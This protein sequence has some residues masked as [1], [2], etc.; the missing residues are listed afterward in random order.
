[1]TCGRISLVVCLALFSLHGQ[2]AS[3]SCSGTPSIEEA[4]DR[5]EVVFRGDVRELRIVKHWRQWSPG[6]ILE[7]IVVSTDDVFISIGGGL[8]HPEQGLVS[9]PALYALFDVD[10][11]WKGDGSRSV[12]IQTSASE[13]SCGSGFNIGAQYLVYANWSESAQAYLTGLCTR[14]KRLG[15]REA[16]EEM[17]R[18]PTPFKSE[19]FPFRDDIA[20][21]LQSGS[22]VVVEGDRPTGR[23]QM[24]RAIP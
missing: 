2:A 9:S 13:T 15:T 6:T 23:R 20:A 7:P 17:A 11:Y 22:E 14:T 21:R 5:A 3:C 1:M 18:L 24:S 16:S 8:L 19:G 10:D 12:W 4:L